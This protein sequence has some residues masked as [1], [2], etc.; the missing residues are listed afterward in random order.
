MFPNVL[1]SLSVLVLSIIVACGGSPDN[2]PTG[3]A[4]TAVDPSSGSFRGGTSA[5]IYGHG[6]KAGAT[7]T[8]G[9]IR[10]TVQ[11][12]S[13]DNIWISATPP[14]ALG[15]VNVVVTNPDGGVGTCVNCFTYI[16]TPVDMARRVL[17]DKNV[18]GIEENERYFGIT[19]SA[20]DKEKYSTQGMYTEATL[21][22]KKDTHILV[23]VLP[24]ISILDLQAK[25]PAGT[26]AFCNPFNASQLGSAK[27]Y[28]GSWR[29]I[30]KDVAPGTLGLPESQ[31]YP[32]LAGLPKE[33]PP[34]ALPLVYALAGH[35]LATGEVLM[36]DIF[37]R[38]LTNTAPGGTNL[39]TSFVGGNAYGAVVGICSDW[40]EN[41][42][43]VIGLSAEWYPR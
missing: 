35:Y 43:P 3:P 38:T 27:M 1:K 17:G 8:F 37:G 41:A 22:A 18:F 29:L 7:V 28:A 19:L 12:M 32:K 6:F 16:E 26:I 31:Q 40:G 4:V 23:L 11:T 5:L 36:P 13:A 30:R 9:G 39:M 33:A 25:L 21:S 15:T 10:A 2:G 14:H 20:A 24:G 42:D 34:E